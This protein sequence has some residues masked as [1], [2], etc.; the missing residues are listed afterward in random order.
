MTAAAYEKWLAAHLPA[1]LDSPQ[2]QSHCSLLGT[3]EQ[4]LGLH[5]LGLAASSSTMVTAFHL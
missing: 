3:A 1:I 2:Y 5:R 4:L